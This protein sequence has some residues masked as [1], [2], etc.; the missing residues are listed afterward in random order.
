MYRVYANLIRR[1]LNPESQRWWTY[2]GS[3]YNFA[4]ENDIKVISASAAMFQ[5]TP[6]SLLPRHRNC[7][8]R[9]NSIRCKPEVETVPKTKSTNNNIALIFVSVAKLLVFPVWGTFSTSG[10]YLMLFS[11]IRKMLVPVEVDRAC[12]K[13]VSYS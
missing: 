7:P 1:F 9:D 10:L 4:T 13:T 5:G 11:E 2:T 12:T 8:T 6:D 3:S